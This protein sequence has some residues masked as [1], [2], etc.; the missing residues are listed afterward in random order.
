MGLSNLGKAA[1]KAADSISQ[2]V[3]AVGTLIKAQS[4]V[5]ILPEPARIKSHLSI[6]RLRL[7]VPAVLILSSL[8]HLLSIL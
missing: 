1:S 8:L 5:R 2:G 7:C 4:G 6:D 3:A